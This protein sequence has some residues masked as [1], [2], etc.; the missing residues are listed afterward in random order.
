MSPDPR[1]VTWHLWSAELPALVAIGL[2]KLDQAVEKTVERRF[3]GEKV[4]TSDLVGGLLARREGLTL[5]GEGA[6]TLQA[7]IVGRQP[8]HVFGQGFE[9]RG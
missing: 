4:K 7:R 9:C 8:A 3:G 6:Q 1:V 5:Y 2:G